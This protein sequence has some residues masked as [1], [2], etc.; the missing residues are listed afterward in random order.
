MAFAMV[1]FLLSL[2]G[3]PFVA[4]FWAKLYVFMAA[5]QAGSHWLVLLGALFAVVALFYYLQV[6]RAM[7]MNEPKRRV[8]KV[9]GEAQPRPSSIGRLSAR[10]RRDGGVPRPLRRRR[11]RG[12][13]DVL[14]LTPTGRR[15]K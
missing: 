5:W 12:V 14:H 8:S 7:Y 11:A 3:I 6:V 4:G 9:R 13:C 2:A 15:F 1:L 10:G